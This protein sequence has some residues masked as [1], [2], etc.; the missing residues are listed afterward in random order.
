MTARF[1]MIHGA[2]TRPSVYDAVVH[3]LTRAVPAVDVVTPARPSSGDLDTELATLLP[4]VAGRLVAG[5]SGGATLG[6]ALLAA[7]ADIRGAVLHEPAAGSLAPGL[8]DAVAAAYRTGGVR[9]FARTLYG[10][11]WHEDHSPEDPRAVG[12]DLAMFRG[13]EPAP[14]LDPT[15]RAVLTVGE[16]SPP[17]RHE[18]VERLAQ[19]FG[20]KVQ[21][22]PGCGHAAHLDAPDAWA[23]ILLTVAAC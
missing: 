8:L 21:V 7:G 1:A 4:A 10:A 15:V 20:Y 11:S 12:R 3:A 19:T 2:A 17:I 18:V 9:G 13:F 6:L 16:L 5:V 14:R 23:A 22:V